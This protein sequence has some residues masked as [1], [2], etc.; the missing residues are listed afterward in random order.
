MIRRLSIAMVGGLAAA[1]G[2]GIAVRGDRD[3][4]ASLPQGDL[5]VLAIGVDHY[6]DVHSLSYPARDAGA[7]ARSVSTRASTSFRRVE[8]RLLTDDRADRQGILDGL[9]WLRKSSRP[10]DV[11]VLYYGGHAGNDPPIGFYL[12]PGLYRDRAWRR[13]MITG[14]E[15]RRRVGEIPGRVVVLLDTCY[16]GA[17]IDES[18]DLGDG[19]AAYLV[20]T[21]AGESNRGVSRARHCDFTQALLDALDGQ[22]DADGDGIITLD[23]LGR[24]IASRVL[25]HRLGWQ[26]AVLNIPPSLRRVA[27]SRP[28]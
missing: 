12:A 25:E 14:D 16:A 28:G 5:R 20:A 18:P 13:T 11:S 8:T 23:E 21:R 10:E 4:G 26:R 1:A 19:R 6:R 22:G 27:L 2:W 7:V 15:L 17:L 3:R 24:H 9:E